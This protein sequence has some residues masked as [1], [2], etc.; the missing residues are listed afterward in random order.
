MCWHSDGNQGKQRD[1]EQTTRS[2]Q[3]GIVLTLLFG[4][5]FSVCQG[6]QAWDNARQRSAAV[7]DVRMRDTGVA[8]R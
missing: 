7:Q 8:T 3:L 4:W 6:T 1:H 2:R 5:G